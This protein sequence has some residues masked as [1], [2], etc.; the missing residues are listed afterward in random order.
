MCGNHQTFIPSFLCRL[1]LTFENIVHFNLHLKERNEC[2]KI[3]TCI[4]YLIYNIFMH[5]LYRNNTNP[6]I[7]PNMF[8]VISFHGGMRYLS[9]L[10]LEY[11]KVE[12]Y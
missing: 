9:S 5:F 6:S 7:M 1:E 8:N 12:M 11:T 10:C 2:L 3:A 4:T